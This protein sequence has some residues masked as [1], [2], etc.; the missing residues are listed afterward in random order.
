VLSVVLLRGFDRN[1]TPQG[2]TR[3]LLTSNTLEAALAPEIKGKEKP[4]FS[5]CVMNGAEYER[6]VRW[7]I[8]SAIEGI[9]TSAAKYCFMLRR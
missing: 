1:H 5:K 2:I 9:Q 4:A 7:S 6:T 8:A 3:V